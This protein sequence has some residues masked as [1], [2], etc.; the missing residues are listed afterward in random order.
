WLDRD[1]DGMIDYNYSLAYLDPEAAGVPWTVRFDASST[2]ITNP[3]L[4]G[5]IPCPLVYDWNITGPGSVS[6]NPVP[7][8]MTTCEFSKLGDYNVTL[9]VKGQQPGTPSVLIPSDSVT[10]KVT[11]KDLLI[12]S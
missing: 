10:Q 8:V 6:C 5:L 3:P 9:T 11:V 7:S 4:C 12:V 2:G 1:G